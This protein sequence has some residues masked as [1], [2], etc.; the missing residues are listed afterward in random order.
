MIKSCSSIDRR[1]AVGG[2]GRR[3]AVCVG[4]RSRTTGGGIFGLKSCS[5]L[6]SFGLVKGL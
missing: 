5:L 6:A 4:G 1:C 3:C 2:G